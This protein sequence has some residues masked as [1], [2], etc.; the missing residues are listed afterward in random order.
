M[1]LAEEWFFQTARAV[2]SNFHYTYRELTASLAPY[3]I[4]PFTQR[5]GF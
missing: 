4:E 1:I 5:F 2:L 3:A